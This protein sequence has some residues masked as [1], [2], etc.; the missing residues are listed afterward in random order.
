[1]PVTLIKK[2]KSRQLDR[3]LKIIPTGSDASDSSDEDEGGPVTMANMEARSRALDAEAA[4]EAEL[5]LEEMQNAVFAGEEEE[6]LDDID[7]DMDEQDAEPFQL[8][9]AEDRE[10]EKKLGGPDIHIVQRR[11]RQCVRILGNFRKLGKGR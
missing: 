5:D 6:D 3:P 8:P 9:T 4:K 7:D 2:S 11:M 1:M 10:Q